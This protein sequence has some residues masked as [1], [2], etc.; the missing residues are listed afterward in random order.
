MEFPRQEYWSGLPCPS[1][2]DLPNPGIKKPCL[3]LGRRI[4]HHWATSSTQVI[5]YFLLSRSSVPEQGNPA[6]TGPPTSY[7]RLHS[8]RPSRLLLPQST[9]CY[10][11]LG[12]SLIDLERGGVY[13][14][15]LAAIDCELIKPA[16]W[17]EL[18]EQGQRTPCSEDF[19]PTICIQCVCV[20]L[21]NKQTINELLRRGNRSKFF[22]AGGHTG[23]LD[24]WK[25]IPSPN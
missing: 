20:F 3:L 2:G 22:S 14:C 16:F 1:P 15:N 6:R 25:G 24:P 10:R 8:P 21:K 11:T 17:K 7:R 18:Q 9:S 23:C 19:T 13:S 4:P 12:C 5:I